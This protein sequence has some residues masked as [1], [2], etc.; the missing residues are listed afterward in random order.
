MACAP[1]SSARRATHA[2]TTAATIWGMITSAA[3]TSS[4]S[5]L[6]CCARRS[7]TSGMSDAL[8]NWNKHHA[9][10]EDQQAMVLHEVEQAHRLALPARPG[11]GRASPRVIDLAAVDTAERDEGGRAQSRRGQE[12]RARR[13][14]LPEHPHQAGRE[15]VAQGAVAAVP[16][17]TRAQAAVPDQAER[18]GG[19]RGPGDAARAAIGDLRRQHE[20]KA[21]EEGEDQRT[22]RDQDERGGDQHPLRA[23][24]IDEGTAWKLARDRGEAAHGEHEPDASIRPAL[25]G[26]IDRDERTEARLD[27]GHEEVEPVEAV[28]A[29]LR[30]LCLVIGH[31]RPPLPALS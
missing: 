20:R 23:H 26:E 28:L 18:D 25:G 5:F 13:D 21:R 7:L 17:E 27:V 3:V 12:R 14:E 31:G 22:E 24:G 10:G 16:P 15:R 8:V 2:E 6:C 11:L 19:E 4:D 29:A 1:T 30:G 9:P